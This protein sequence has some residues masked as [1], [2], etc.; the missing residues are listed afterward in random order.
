MPAEF[1]KEFMPDVKEEF[2]KVVASIDRE[3]FLSILYE[4]IMTK[5]NNLHGALLVSEGKEEER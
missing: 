4:V 2:D 3:E 5:I 1:G